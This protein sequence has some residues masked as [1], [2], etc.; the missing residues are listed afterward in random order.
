MKTMNN[1]KGP[2]IPLVHVDKKS[3]EMSKE[4]FMKNNNVTMNNTSANNTKLNFEKFNEDPAMVD[5][6]AG[7][8]DS[9]ETCAVKSWVDLYLLLINWKWFTV[10]H[11]LHTARI[12]SAIKKHKHTQLYFQGI[13][14]L[15]Y[16]SVVI[17]AGVGISKLRLGLPI[18]DVVPSHSA[19]WEFLTAQG[20]LFPVYHMKAVTKANFDYP[21]K[22]K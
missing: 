7:N 4:Y 17:A 3:S 9:C 16:I 15:M 19:E 20:K 14:L 5:L 13:V 11:H 1:I 12:K 8:Q 6:E 18:T 22:Q 10:S 21:S 2:G